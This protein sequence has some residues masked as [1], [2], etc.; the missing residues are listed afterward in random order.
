MDV[1]D[2]EGNRVGICAWQYDLEAIQRG[3]D[4]NAKFVSPWRAE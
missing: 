4:F 2:A 1:F 3:E